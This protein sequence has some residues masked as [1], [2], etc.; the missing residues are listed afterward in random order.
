MQPS[1]IVAEI[2]RF[3]SGIASFSTTRAD[4]TIYVAIIHKSFELHWIGEQAFGTMEGERLTL[5]SFLS[6]FSQ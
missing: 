4:A 6:T 2:E 3:S 1:D 5:Y